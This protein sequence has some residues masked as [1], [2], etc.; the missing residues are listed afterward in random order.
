MV[1]DHSELININHLMHLVINQFAF[2]QIRPGPLIGLI[3]KNQSA[4]IS[5]SSDKDGS[6]KFV[7]N[8]WWFSS[9]VFPFVLVKFTIFWLIETAVSKFWWHYV[10]RIYFVTGKSA[11]FWMQITI[12]SQVFNFAHNIVARFDMVL[13]IWFTLC[14]QRKNSTLTGCVNFDN[15]INPAYNQVDNQIQVDWSSS[16]CR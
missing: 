6:G 16:C 2:T 8:V 9:N 1:F 15:I 12:H 7:A 5:N 3:I 14:W 11:R 4:L 10:T 13:C